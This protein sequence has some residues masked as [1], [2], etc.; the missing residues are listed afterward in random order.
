MRVI[1][2]LDLLGGHVVRGMAGRRETYRPIQSQL[3]CGSLPLDVARALRDTYGLDVFYVADLD[4]IM[5]RMPDVATIDL[6]VQD[7]FSLLVDSGVRTSDDARLLVERGVARIIIG[8]ESST[9]LEQVQDVV[10]CIGGQR[11]I[12]SLDLKNGLPLT[13]GPGWDRLDAV[14]I[15]GQ[16]LQLGVD[17]L[18]L[19]D[20]TEVGMGRGVTTDRLASEL[21]RLHPGNRLITGG[22]V[23]NAGD[24]HTQFALGIQGVLVASTLHDGRILPNEIVTYTSGWPG[25]V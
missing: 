11:I 9:G 20:L 8:L 24:L 18:I 4:G 15:G 3:K 7:G 12:F 17:G 10:S 22:G 1:P 14:E 16:V 5:Q 25:A 13:G 21:L 2:V 23:R 19:L 6:L